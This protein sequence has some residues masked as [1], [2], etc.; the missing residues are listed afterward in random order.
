MN[1]YYIE[2]FKELIL[3]IIQKTAV[4]S[5]S[6]F[7]YFESTSIISSIIR[8]RGDIIFEHTEYIFIKDIEDFYSAVLTKEHY[9]SNKGKIV[10]VYIPF[11]ITRVE[12][13][14]VKKY[15]IRIERFDG[16]KFSNRDIKKV[17]RIIDEK[18]KTYPQIDFEYIKSIYQK[19]VFISASLGSIFSKSIRERDAFKF[20]IRGLE[21]IFGFDRIRMYILDES[22]NLLKGV[23]AV[24]R[25]GNISDISHQVIPMIRG[26]CSLVDVLLD[27]EDLVIRDNIVY[28]PL[29]IDFKNRGLLSVDNLLSR[30]DIN[31]YYIDIL[32]SFS[33]L[34]AIAFEN[35][36]LFE[37]IQSMS[38]YDELTGLALR[39][40][41]NQK[42]QEEF[43]RAERFSQNLSVIWL[44]IDYF[45]EINDSYGHQIGDLVLIEISNVIKKTLRKIDFPARYG[46]DEIVILLPQSSELEAMGLA[47][48]L[49]E[50]IR[51]LKIDLS[52][53]G[54]DKV[55]D[56]SVSIGIASYPND[57]KTMDEL[58][59]KADEAL[60]WVKS[61]G[62]NGFISYSMMKKILENKN[63]T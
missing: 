37:K 61:N 56:L 51:S 57:A 24:Y 52:N 48:R 32:K 12:D 23:Y 27:G 55:I 8:F 16:K 47:K 31:R 15:L 42:F 53:F 5:I 33:S 26:S 59:M 58:L 63:R 14:F 50:N 30:I 44:D 17:R 49:V 9:V 25:T 6:L 35:I 4:K 34:M 38:L 41:F 46:G 29:R 13:G 60:Y 19:S 2:F 10:F 28:I 43:Y 39:R 20:M 54:I 62:R 40:Y 45:K 36:L 3:E 22:T 1:R 11:D 18:I 7:E 21:N